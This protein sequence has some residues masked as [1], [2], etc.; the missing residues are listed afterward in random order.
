MKYKKRRRAPK[1][2]RRHIQQRLEWAHEHNGFDE[3]FWGNVAFSDEKR[4]TLD[5]PDGGKSWEDTRVAQE[6][7]AR[8]H[9]GGGSIMAW[10]GFCGAQKTTLH[11]FNGTVNAPT[12]V[13]TLEEHLIPVF[14][15]ELQIFQQDNAPSHT[16]RY[17]KSW[18][19][20]KNIDV[21]S[22]PPFSP[23][24]NP[25]ENVWAYLTNIVYKNGKQ[26]YS[27]EALKRAIL[28]AWN[29]MPDSYLASLV[30]SMP[31]RVQAVVDAKG[32]NTHY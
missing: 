12:Y 31:D 7:N 14:D 9:S 29:E 30:K 4:W 13:A 17:T 21:L 20:S 19:K 16:A 8:R 18:L 23:D 11:F 3:Y 24:M 32:K 28:K 25:I 27:L 2:E 1:L 6:P 15:T 10:G 26:F 5:G 22:W